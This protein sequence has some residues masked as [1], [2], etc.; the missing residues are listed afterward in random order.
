MKRSVSALV[1]LTL[2][3]LSA[4]FLFSGCAGRQ[5]NDEG[6]ELYQ[7]GNL[8]DAY[9]VQF[10]TEA[11]LVQF[12]QDEKQTA[13]FE[14]E[15]IP[16]YG[17]YYRL[18]SLPC[19]V[20]RMEI[21]YTQEDVML[22]YYTDDPEFKKQSG[23]AYTAMLTWNRDSGR[24]QALLQEAITLGVPPVDHEKSVGGRTVYYGE[25][26]YPSD[27]EGGPS[28]FASGYYFIQDGFFFSVNINLRHSDKNF[29]YCGL[30]KVEAS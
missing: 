11:E 15:Q 8:K 25:E 27:E 14:K 20:S 9:D 5:E 6:D 3:V 21:D 7:G 26:E 24:A 22:S 29:N 2:L 12:L 19:K 28:T 18:K 30:E 4:V 13:D 10:E 1:S 17:Y 16:V 23:D